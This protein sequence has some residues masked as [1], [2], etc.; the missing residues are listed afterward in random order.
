MAYSKVIEANIFL[1]QITK[2][3]DNIKTLMINP[4][5]SDFRLPWAQWHQ[6]TGLLQLSSFLKQNGVDVRLVDFLHTNNKQIVKRKYTTTVRGNYTIPLWHFGLSNSTDITNKIKKQLTYG[7]RPNA[8]FFTS[9]NTIWWKDV[10]E[11]IEA[12]HNLLPGIPIYLGGIYPSYELEHAKKYSGAD[13]IITGHTNQL[14]HYSLDALL[15]QT[16]P[17]SIGIYFYYIDQEGK[18]IPRP[19]EA[20]LNEIKTQT[21]LGIFEFAF[22]DE[23]IKETDKPTFIDLLDLIIKSG[24][25][26]KFALLGNISAKTIDKKIAAKLKSAGFRKIY[27]RCNLDLN[28]KD[29]FSDTLADYQK[30]MHFLTSNDKYRRG[31]DDISAM[32]IVGVPFE[33][34]KAVTKRIISLAHIVGSVIPVP[35]QYVPAN[36]NAFSFGLDTSLNGNNPLIKFISQKLNSPEKFNSKLYPFA[37]IS[38]YHFEEYVELTRLATL[39][40]SKYRGTTFDFLG[41]SFTAKRFR[42][43]IRTKGWDPFRDIRSNETVFINDSLLESEK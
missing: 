18:Q 6:P 35:F 33:D 14:T 11:A 8:V 2:N 7:W 37:E 29:Y 13:F 20:L 28:K 43:S 16:P 9:L 23:E 1:D 4:F 39:L 31:S 30:A 3:Q 26:A 5:V 22:F 17:K 34:L 27:F 38:G 10:K 25:K 42:E 19:T 12:C 36:H 32:V 21:E 15:Y 24:I 40:N 41:N